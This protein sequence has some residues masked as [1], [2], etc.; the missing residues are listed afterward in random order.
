M[1]AILRTQ[2]A[3]E[4]Q[5]GFWGIL[6][7]LWKSSRDLKV[8]NAS[9]KAISELPDGMLSEEFI[10]SQIP[11]LQKLL[12]SIE[13]L[14]D[15]GKRRGLTN[16][17]LTSTPFRRIRSLAEYIADYLDALE[18]S[19]DPEVLRAIDEGRDQIERGEFEAM[20]RLF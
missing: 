18:M 4:R 17:T 14:C 20:E 15:V 3:V 1:A 13:N 9:L 10:K 7:A 16:R 2:E 8:L 19:I 12:R 5:F 6:N 11:Q